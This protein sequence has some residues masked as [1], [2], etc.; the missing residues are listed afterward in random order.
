MGIQIRHTNGPQV[1]E[2]MLNITNHQGNA[3]QNHRRTSSHT[4]QDGG[5]LKKKKAKVTRTQECNRCSHYAKRM[6]IPQ[7]N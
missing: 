1:C 6:E 7:K 5:C 2:K 4:Y 3:S